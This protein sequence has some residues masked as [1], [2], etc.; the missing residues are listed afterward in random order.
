LL[1]IPGVLP[2]YVQPLAVPFSLLLALPLWECPERIRA[3]WRK[4]VVTLTILLFLVAVSAPFIIAAAVTR[5]GDA[6]HPGVAG[7]GI[8]FVFCGALLLISLRKPLRESVHLALWTGF[9]AAMVMLLYAIAAVPWIRLK[10]GI[11]PFAQRIDAAAPDGATLFAYSL[12]D[13]APLLATLFYLRKTPVAYAPDPDSAPDGRQLY[14][15]RGKDDRKFRNR[16]RIEGEPIA[17][18]QP[19]GEKSPS[20]VF[21]AERVPR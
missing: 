18:W 16:F 14:L 15:V 6:A 7:L 12:E 2:R 11:R 13:Y 17:S 8:F 9:L 10:D 5:G 20:V 4:A 3:W 1:L 21:W 19:E